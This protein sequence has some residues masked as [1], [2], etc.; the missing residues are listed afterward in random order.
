MKHAVSMSLN[1]SL[2]RLI[3]EDCK[4]QWF[5]MFKGDLKV[6]GYSLRAAVLSQK[7]PSSRQVSQQEDCFGMT[8]L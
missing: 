6:H 7:L 1:F 8:Y 4:K 2:L 5:N 3:N